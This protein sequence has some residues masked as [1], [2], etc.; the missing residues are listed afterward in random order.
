MLDGYTHIDPITAYPDN[1]FVSNLQ[2]FLGRIA[3]R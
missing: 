1:D 3:K 2:R